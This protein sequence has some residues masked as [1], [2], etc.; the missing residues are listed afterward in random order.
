MDIKKILQ[1]IDGVEK[2]KKPLTEAT[3]NIAFNADSADEVGAMLDRLRGISS[4]AT[5]APTPSMSSDIQKFKSAVDGIEGPQLPALANAPDVSISGIDAVTGSGDDLH[6]SKN[7]AD[8]RVK[9]ASIAQDITDWSNEPDEAVSDHNT[10]IKDL[11]GGLNGEKKMY[12]PAAKGDNPMQT[13]KWKAPQEGEF[14]DD[15]AELSIRWQMNDDGFDIEAYDAN[16]NLVRLSP[17]QLQSYEQKIQSELQDQSDE[18]GDYEFHRRMETESIKSRLL[19]ALTEKMSKPDFLD[20]DKDGNKK[21][22]MKKAL[23][24][25]KKKK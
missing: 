3:M 25:R 23:K 1:H 9:D 19:K 5:S 10:M 15:D 16:E 12:K 21:E 8:I 17:M 11:S 14:Y 20:M 6:K 2:T 4:P 22:P 13:E 18:Y 7:P 24:D